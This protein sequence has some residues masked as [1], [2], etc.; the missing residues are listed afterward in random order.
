MI[1]AL[2]QIKHVTFVQ[3]SMARSHHPED[4]G[5]LGDLRPPKIEFPG[6]YYFADEDYVCS[7]PGCGWPS[8]CPNVFAHGKCSQHRIQQHTQPA[9]PTA[10]S[11]SKTD[12]QSLPP[13]PVSNNSSTIASTVSLTTNNS[14]TNASTVSSTTVA[15]PT[16]SISAQASSSDAKVTVTSLS[17]QN[18]SAHSPKPAPSDFKEDPSWPAAGF[19]DP[20]EG[21]H[22]DDQGN[23]VFD[24]D[25]E[26]DQEILIPQDPDQQPDDFAGPSSSSYDSRSRLSPPVSP[27]CSPRVSREAENGDLATGSHAAGESGCESLHAGGPGPVFFSSS[28]DSPSSGSPSPTP[29]ALSSSSTCTNQAC[30]S[31]QPSHDNLV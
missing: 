22:I 10:E 15:P 20:Y 12:T 26:P 5:F 25:G 1:P 19:E 27:R 28:A 2:K 7:E 13:V 17:G 9:V 21:L 4:V 3:P 18:V 6:P 16:T 11:D 14:S 31:E 30:A 24:D 23:I 29:R 8:S